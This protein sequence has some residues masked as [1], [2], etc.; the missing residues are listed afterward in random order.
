MTKSFS[1]F[2][3]SEINSSYS[4]EVFFNDNIGVEDATKVLEGLIENNNILLFPSIDGDITIDGD[5]KMTV[6]YTGYYEDES[7]D[8]TK[9]VEDS[10]EMNVSEVMDLV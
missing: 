3:E 8:E 5:G 2:I 10:F 9:P 7:G 4:T 6:E 1:F